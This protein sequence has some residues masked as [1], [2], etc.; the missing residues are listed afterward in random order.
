MWYLKS[1][2]INFR[3]EHFEN[4]HNGL[5]LCI[6]PNSFL[7]INKSSEKKEHKLQACPWKSKF[8]TRNCFMHTAGYMYALRNKCTDALQVA[9]ALLS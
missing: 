1:L 7:M 8:S 2:M 4:M 9:E 3:A 5:I 6:I